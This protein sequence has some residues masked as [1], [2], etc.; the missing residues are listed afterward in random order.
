MLILIVKNCRYMVSLILHT[1][2]SKKY[3][4]SLGLDGTGGLRWLF[5]LSSVQS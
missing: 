1:K 2:I 3:S 4:Y 5:I